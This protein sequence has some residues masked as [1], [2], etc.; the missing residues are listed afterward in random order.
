M[1]TMMA[2]AWRFR[3]SLEAMTL[4]TTRYIDDVATA[5]VLALEREVTEALG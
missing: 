3:Y 5:F 2:Y 4:K 1:A